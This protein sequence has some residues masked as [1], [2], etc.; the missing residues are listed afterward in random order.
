MSTQSPGTTKMQCNPHGTFTQAH[1][2]LLHNM[3]HIIRH[4]R[5]ERSTRSGVS[6]V[7]LCEFSACCHCRLAYTHRSMYSTECSL[8]GCLHNNL[9]INLTRNIHDIGRQDCATAIEND[10]VETS[11]K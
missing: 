9:Q 3:S 7:F 10:I 2:K 4:V 11:P 8:C 1:K 6:S 5:P